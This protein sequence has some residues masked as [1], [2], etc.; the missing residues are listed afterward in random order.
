[1]NITQVYLT[2]DYDTSDNEERARYQNE[3]TY[4][5]LFVEECLRK[6]K[7]VLGAFNR[8]VFSEGGDSTRDF[9]VVGNNAL[10]VAIS[11]TRGELYTLESER[12]FHDYYIRK[13]L[14]GFQKFDEHF[15]STFV[16]NLKPLISAKYEGGLNY[17]K[18]M[19]SKPI[20]GQRIQV[21]GSYD[22]KSFKLLVNVYTK[23]ELLKSIP[24]FEC[25]PDMFIVKYEAHKVEIND[26]SIVVINKVRE[27]TLEREI[28]EFI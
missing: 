20:D 3:T 1:M 15:K 4:I 26:K 25:E 6:N 10:P 21:V 27:K 18:Q 5:Q 28:A 11:D 19:A 12:D 23:K 8:L 24:I 13:L 7:V 14:E 22:R 17:E 16:S 9:N 2:T